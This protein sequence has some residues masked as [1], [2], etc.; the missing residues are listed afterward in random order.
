MEFE[1]YTN[2]KKRMM[3]VQVVDQKSDTF[4]RQIYII[5]VFAFCVCIFAFF[6]FFQL[7][8][9]ISRWQMARA[10]QEQLQN[11][12]VLMKEDLCQP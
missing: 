4:F 3:L 10:K 2:N 6:T 8:L 12:R 9:H 11:F 1:K 5:C 7:L